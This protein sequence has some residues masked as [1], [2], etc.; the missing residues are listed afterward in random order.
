MLATKADSWKF[1]DTDIPVEKTPTLCFGWSS[2]PSVLG[3]QLANT[4]PKITARHVFATVRTKE[5]ENLDF[6]SVA[7]TFQKAS[8]YV[9]SACL[10]R[11]AEVRGSTPLCSTI[12]HIASLAY[13]RTLQRGPIFRLAPT[14]PNNE[15]QCQTTGCAGNACQIVCWL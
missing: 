5:Q 14:W 8:T 7:A 4:W 2:T 3:I 9:F 15:T 6:P 11:N 1:F 12:D 13:N 10:I